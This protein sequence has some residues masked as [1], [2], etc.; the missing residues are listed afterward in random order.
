MLAAAG[1]FRGF[2]KFIALGRLDRQPSEAD[3]GNPK[4]FRVNSAVVL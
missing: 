4:I 1:L 2:G 3:H